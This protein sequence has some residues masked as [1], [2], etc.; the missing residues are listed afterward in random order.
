MSNEVRI[1]LHRRLV[2]IFNVNTRKRM[3]NLFL[4]F[5]MLLQILPMQAFAAWDGSGD[6]NGATDPVN[7]EY[8]LPYGDLLDNL[9][10]YRFSVYANK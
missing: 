8:W 5:V 10:G 9:V 6:S 7:G 3:L 2:S 1:S 4:V